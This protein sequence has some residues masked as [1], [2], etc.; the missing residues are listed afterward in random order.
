MAWRIA[1][2]GGLFVLLV[3]VDFGELGIDDVFFLGVAA[4]AGI[5]TA[6]RLLIG[7]LLVHCLTELHRS[8]RQRIGLGRDG[9]RIRT[10]QSFLEVGHGVFDGAAFDLADFP[11]MLGER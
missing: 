1:R 10:L 9:F 3:V 8:L 2:S 7:S 5:V 4:G 11:A 6:T